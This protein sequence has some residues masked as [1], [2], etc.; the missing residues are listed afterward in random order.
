MDLTTNPHDGFF[1]ALMERP[2]TAGALLRER[3]PKALADQIVG[4]PELVE[5]SFIDDRLRRS[6]CDRLYRVRLRSGR[7][8]YVYCLIEH[9]SRPEPR[10]ALQVLRYLARIWESHERAHE[11]GGLLPAVLPLVVYQGKAKWEVPLRFSGIV[12]AP[13]ETREYLLDFPFGLLDL[14]QVE[15]RELSREPELRAGLRVL[16]Y[17]KRVGK[18]NVAE[19]VEQVVA[20]VRSS[21]PGLMELAVRYII[22]GYGSR[23]LGWSKVKSAM[24]RT[25]SEKERK[26]LS[27]A[28]R[29]LLDEGKRE[30]IRVGE[31][32]G[33]R[34]GRREGQAAALIQVLERRFR[35]LPVRVRK[36]IAGASSGE[37]KAWLDRAVDVAAL[38]AVFAPAAKH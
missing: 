1:R 25:L 8:A 5:G 38:E 12:D 36:Q 21:A 26:M 30:G 15:D 20:E 13:E 10:V 18:G 7:E 33:E 24:K 27:R 4:E 35:R 11:K 29:D 3:L 32:K 9:K 17:A 37:L 2:H 22:C 23:R 6:Q 34:K 31:R 28:A 16:K 19:V 14:G